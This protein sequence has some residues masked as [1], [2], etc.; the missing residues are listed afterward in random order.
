MDTCPDSLLSHSPHPS[1]EISSETSPLSLGASHVPQRSGTLPRRPV[2]ADASRRVE[3]LANFFGVNDEDVLAMAQACGNAQKF[4]SSSPAGDLA[5][6]IHAPLA[7]S[8][9]EV[10]VKVSKPTRF[11]NGRMTTRRIHPDDVR[12]KL[13]AMRAS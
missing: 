5:V 2:T 12:D 11:W 1:V 8:Q 6:G 13:R 9:L 10:E 4:Q 7:D 3:K